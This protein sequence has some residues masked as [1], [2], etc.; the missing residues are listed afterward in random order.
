MYF[1]ADRRQLVSILSATHKSIWIYGQALLAICA[2][3]GESA[4]GQSP[5]KSPTAARSGQHDYARV[6]TVVEVEGSLHVTGTSKKTRKL[7][8]KV[9]GELFFDERTIRESGLRRVRHYWD[10]EAE[11]DVDNKPQERTLRKDRNIILLTD[12]SPGR[13]RFTSPLGALT[14]AELELIDI[15]VAGL[16]PERLLPGQL[17]KRQGE[18]KHSNE[19]V[20]GLLG[21][22]EVRSGQLISKLV[23]VTDSSCKIEIS[24]QVKG[25]VEGTTTSIE[26]LG[27][28]QLDRTAN[29]VRWLALSLKETRESG[30]VAPGFSVVTR[31][32]T[33]RQPIDV[34]PVLT[35]KILESLGLD[36]VAASQPLDFA[37]TDS[38]YRMLLDR[39]WYVLSQH[40]D[41]T[42][43]RMVD[44]G[45]L[46]GTCKLDRLHKLPPG[47]Q[48]SLEN[49]QTDVRRALATNCEQILEAEETVN[50]QGVRML[51][52]VA[53]GRVADI[54]VR[55]IYY[56]L[57]DGRGP[58]LSC[59]FTHEASVSD[60]FDGLDR[61][62]TS[63][64][65][66]L[67]PPQKSEQ[68][69]RLPA[70]VRR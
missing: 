3:V 29:F 63:S 14:R 15:P 8:L 5:V 52:V 59:I 58:R 53:G 61:A 46:L 13:S 24:G 21:L 35:D 19:V 9:R 16:R 28:Y 68:H 33:I 23:E 57:S 70:T 55:W 62:L 65:E 25:I 34:S 18:W 30:F 1:D 67:H 48:L 50:T 42:V 11:L 2:F 4:A 39:R 31:V 27:N 43:L 37:P 12:G 49:F 64:I 45:D 41:T 60:R 32:R 38:Q 69:A 51:R 56:H 6:K 10:A 20:A 26:V 36:E 40:G 47:K 7:P 17:P 44:D 54:P 66:F 22:D